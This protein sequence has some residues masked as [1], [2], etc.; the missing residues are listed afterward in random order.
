M[1][2]ILIH[3]ARVVRYTYICIEFRRGRSNKPLSIYYSAPKFQ[4]TRYPTTGFSL[5][6]GRK[7]LGRKATKKG[8]VI[9]NELV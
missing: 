6:V 8:G 9:F 7:I 2:I 1:A 3:L 5:A 4:K